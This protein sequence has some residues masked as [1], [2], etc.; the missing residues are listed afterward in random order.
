MANETPEQK[1]AELEAALTAA[2][3]QIEES[4]AARAAEERRRA[5]DAAV[6]GAVDAETARILVE[7]ALGKGELG[8]VNAAAA[9][10]VADLKRRKPFLF[11]PPGASGAAAPATRP[12]DTDLRDAAERAAHTGDRRE[13]LRYMRAK[14]SAR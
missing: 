8:D 6:A 14:R 12:A 1:I 13:L 4:K 2:K 3:S 7:H 9:N 5:V 10:I 11:A